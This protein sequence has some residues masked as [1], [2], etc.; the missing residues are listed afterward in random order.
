MTDERFY[1]IAAHLAVCDKS[2]RNPSWSVVA[3]LYQEV[4][5]LREMHAD[6]Q[7]IIASLRRWG[8]VRWGRDDSS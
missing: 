7:A 1:E 4:K 6:I 5:D 8:A 3:E 2:R